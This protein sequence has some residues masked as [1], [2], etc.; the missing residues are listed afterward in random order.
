VTRDSVSKSLKIYASHSEREMELQLCVKRGKAIKKD[1][2]KLI[3]QIR[4]IKSAAFRL[5]VKVFSK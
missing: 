1:K 2:K 3:A 5:N 4:E